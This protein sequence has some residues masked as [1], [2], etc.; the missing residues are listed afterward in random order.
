MPRPH[1]SHSAVTLADIAAAMG[2][3]ESTVS[4]SFSDPS[5]VSART[6]ERVLHAAGELGY[7]PP[8]PGKPRRTLEGI[9]VIVPDIANPFFPPIIKAIQARASAYAM[10]S[11]IVD[12][13][14][15]ARDELASGQ[16]LRE[17]V[18]GLILVSP[19]A[20]EDELRDL[21]STIPTV[22]INR[23]LPFSSSVTV[24]SHDAIEKA[25][26]HLWALGHRDLA[27]LNGPE[28]S[29]SNE[30]RRSV[31]HKTSK[32]LGLELTEF[33]PFEP[34]MSAGVHAADLVLASAA[35]AVI[36]Y[37][38]LIALGLMA[39]LQSRGLRVGH[40]MSVV[41][42][43]DSPLSATA[44]PSLTT[45]Q[46]PGSRAGEL[47][48]DELTTLIDKPGTPVTRHHL[49]ASLVVRESTGVRPASPVAA[50]K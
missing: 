36:A 27:Y 9:G 17:R 47:A 41:G 21:A 16:F 28:Q 38:D 5:K 1:D 42:I 49:H 11:L 7:R 40:D 10:P 20:S 48:V 4:R 23:E 33:G 22:I 14:E 30:Q 2:V 44:Y 50:E 29:W 6:R 34:G 46:L 25:V 45:I 3:S 43:D 26:E 8:A 39:R 32:R 12:T 13:D 15:R 18:S 24:D 37:D 19:R 35:T 31:V